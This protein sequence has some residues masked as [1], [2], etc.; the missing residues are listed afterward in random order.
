MA[1]EIT[2]TASLEGDN[3]IFDRVLNL[4][5]QRF[6][7][8]AALASQK[9]QQGFQ[10]VGTSEEAINLGDVSTLGWALFI[11]RDTTNFISLKTATGGTVF[12]KLPPKGGCALFH[13][14]SG[15]TAP[16]AVADTAACNMEYLIFTA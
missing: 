1:A 10:N 8:T 11:N 12:A 16:W 14:G 13:F 5:G 9:Y 4:S 15:V 2:L 3:S 6:D 7:F